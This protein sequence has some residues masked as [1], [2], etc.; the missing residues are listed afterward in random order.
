MKDK[1]ISKLMKHDQKINKTL[2]QILIFSQLRNLKQMHYYNKCLS[3]E[4]FDRCWL[5][6]ILSIIVNCIGSC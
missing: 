6:A 4:F 5:Q 2:N 1:D 3:S